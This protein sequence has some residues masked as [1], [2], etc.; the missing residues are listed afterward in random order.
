MGKILR[1]A[2]ASDARYLVGAIGTLASVRLAVPQEV[3]IEV[4]YLHDSLTEKDQERVWRAMSRLKNGPKVE[5]LK[6]DADFSDFPDFYFGSNMAYARL[7]LPDKLNCDKMI[8]IDVDILVL[9]DL[10][11]LLEIEL[12]SSGVG[13]A[14]EHIKPTLADEWPIEMPCELNPKDPYLNSGVLLLDIPKVRE[15]GIF[16]RALDILRR[17][18]K[19]CRYHDQSAINY[20]LQGSVHLLDPSW[21]VQT[22]RAAL[23][24]IDCVPDLQARRLNVH[25]ISKIKPWLAPVPFPAQKMFRMLLDAV[26]PEWKEDPYYSALYRKSKHHSPKRWPL[27]F[28]ARALAKRLK[29]KDAFLDFREAKIWDEYNRD[30]ERLKKVRGEI[31]HLYDGWKQQIQSRLVEHHDLTAQG[32]HR[33]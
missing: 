14:V 8:Y 3:S 18:P 23:D 21:N 12:P 2:V 33:A 7:L 20:A 10:S 11:Q 13:G 29:G 4:V 28:R 30:L 16:H 9:K 22:H 32:G 17:T 27:L 5:F 26:E 24:P 1:L 25:F 19:A 6:F 15:S 31:G